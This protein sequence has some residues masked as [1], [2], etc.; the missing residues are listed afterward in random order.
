[1]EIGN[2]NF[3]TNGGICMKALILV[4]ALVMTLQYQIATATSYPVLYVRSGGLAAWPCGTSIAN[5]CKNIATA[6][7]NANVYAT[8]SIKVAQGDYAEWINILDVTL[9]A[10]GSGQLA[11]EG[12]WN[13]DFTTQS[14]DPTKTRITSSNTNAVVN[15]APGTGHRV[16][17]RLAYL[18]LRGT[19]DLQRQ[20]L[21][22]L[23]SSST[24]DLDIEHCHIISFRGQGISLIADT[25]GQATVTVQDTTIQGNYQVG[26]PWTG[27]GMYISSWS[28]S[29]VEVTLTQNTIVDNQATAGGGINLYTNGAT[30]NTTL[31]NNIVAGNQVV[32]DGGASSGCGRRGN[33]CSRSW[34]WYHGANPDQQH[35]QQ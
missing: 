3:Y 21:Q 12:G 9:P 29:T 14:P 20:G 6:V 25:G 2:I 27:A 1:V 8:T 26:S 11:I 32:A 24:I 5:S 31:V 34:K 23:P 10:S 33:C 16:G 4:L 15:I 28:G 13:T 22:A 35:H 18:T 19:T 17:L 7:A 30:L